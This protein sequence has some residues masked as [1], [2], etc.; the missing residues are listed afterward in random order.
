MSPLRRTLVAAVVAV[1]PTLTACGDDAAPAADAAPSAADAQSSGADAEP[2]P[3]A[4]PGPDAGPAPY[5]T[6]TEVRNDMPKFDGVNPP[7]GYYEYLPSRYDDDPAKEWPAIVFFTGIGQIGNGNTDLVKVLET[8][9]PSVVNDGA[10]PAHDQFVVLMPQYGDYWHAD[11]VDEFATWAKAHYRLDASRLYLT[12][13]SYGAMATLSYGAARGD[14]TQF[15]AYV[16]ISGDSAGDGCQYKTT[17]MW[18]FHGQDDSNP[19]TLASMSVDSVERINACAPDVPA[20][21]TLYTG[22]GHSSCAWNRTYDLTGMTAPVDPAH[23]A[24]D[25]SIYEWM[26]QHTK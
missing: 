24:Y 12:G 8:G 16:P 2:S 15:A 14:A 10:F 9:L 13:L 4:P 25:Q 26:L 22:C 19:S 11:K 20:K 3:D 23:A 21:V 17:P 7:F 6:L 5:G 18:F 1:L